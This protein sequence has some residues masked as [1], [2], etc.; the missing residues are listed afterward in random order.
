MVATVGD[1]G[2]GSPDD[3]TGL[4]ADC[5]NCF[6]LC[7]VALAFTASQDF[8]I[9]KE[10][11]EPC[12]NLQG[13]DRC[14]I[15]DRLRPRGFS[16]CVTYDCFGAGQRISQVTY[17]G[18]NWRD[19]PGS[20]AEMFRLLPIVRQLQELL[21]YLTEA[22]G[23]VSDASLLADIDALADE[24][25]QL[26]GSLPGVLVDLD[27]AG[28]RAKVN[29]ALL[30][31]S[32]IVRAGAGR[33][34]KD[35]RGADLLGARF[36]GADLRGASFRGAYLIAADLS[37]ADLRLADLIGAD[38]RDTNLRGADL[39]ESLFVTQTQV[40][41]AQGDHRTRL[42]ANLTRPGHWA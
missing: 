27:V 14:G 7:C 32:E 25:D 18:K 2:V 31:V 28:Q 3:V 37:N 33:R 15:H 26:A 17:G 19:H 22:R 10:A 29:V 24:T 21:W 35:H 11:G 1:A 9:D 30:Q 42:P 39:S 8:A 38:L 4:R 41:A 5:S 12:P 6:A 13:D 36:R 16:G 23:R 40:N 20:A 34:R